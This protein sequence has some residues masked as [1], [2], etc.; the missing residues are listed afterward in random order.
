MA[1]KVAVKA[2]DIFYNTWGYD[3]TNVDY[4]EVIKVTKSGKSVYIKKLET[5]TVEDGFMTGKVS[6]VPGKYRGE[7]ML[8]RVKEISWRGGV[9]GL[10]MEYGGYASPWDG[11]PVRGSWYA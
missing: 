3:Q 5:T 7:M 6:P 10:P 1:N 11:N 2:G 4:Y 9:P 8:K